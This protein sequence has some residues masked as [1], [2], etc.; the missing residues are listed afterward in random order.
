MNPRK[1]SRVAYGYMV[2][3]HQRKGLAHDEHPSC[4][5][6]KRKTSRGHFLPE[7][8]PSTEPQQCASATTRR[9][10]SFSVNAVDAGLLRSVGA[11]TCPN[12]GAIDRYGLQCISSYRLCVSLWFASNCPTVF[13]NPFRERDQVAHFVPSRRMIHLESLHGLRQAY[14]STSRNI[15][16]A[17][18]VTSRWKPISR[19]WLRLFCAQ[20]ESLR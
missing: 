1:S 20:A 2:C 7:R 3:P 9:R 14:I 17:Q 16:F 15:A 13:T 10:C 6:G 18:R 12:D 11:V 8:G 19:I 4:V 5:G